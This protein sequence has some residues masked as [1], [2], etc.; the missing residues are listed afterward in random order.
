MTLVWLLWSG[1]YSDKEIVA[2]YSTEAAAESTR[3]RYITRYCDNS[4]KSLA[5]PN[6]EWVK[7]DR[8]RAEEEYYVEA[9]QVD[10]EPD[11]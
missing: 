8:Q 6:P 4:A 11:I 9:R 2:V 1:N 7:G 5:L 3:Q 10:R